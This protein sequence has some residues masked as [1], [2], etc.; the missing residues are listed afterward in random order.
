MF[1]WHVIQPDTHDFGAI[2]SMLVFPT[3]IKHILICQRK[4]NSIADSQYHI[5]FTLL[6][7]NNDDYINGEI[8]YRE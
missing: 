5:L 1:G 4:K 7:D 8:E 6:T 3:R 2:T